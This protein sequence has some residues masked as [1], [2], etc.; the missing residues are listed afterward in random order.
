MLKVNKIDVYYGDVQILWEVSLDV[1]E[2][3]IISLIGP[4]GAGKTTI[5]RTIIGLKAPKSGSITF[6]DKRIDGLSPHKIVGL[7]VTLVPER[8]SLFETMSVYENLLMGGYLKS[9]EIVRDTIEEVYNM[10]PVL[11]ERNNQFA[12]T[13][14]GGERRMLTVGRAIMSKPKL[15]ILDE[16]TLGLMPTLVVQVL[17]TIPKLRD[18]GITLVL[19][20]ENVSSSLKLADRGYVIEEGK[21]AL[22]GTGKELLKNPHIKKVY[23]GM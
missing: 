9:P 1:K 21:I 12:G 3:E 10:F 2:G 23:L 11:K 17:D 20:E 16:P 19:I 7:G 13:L 4:N 14:S 22:E 18:M 8:R 15:M 6:L 5:A